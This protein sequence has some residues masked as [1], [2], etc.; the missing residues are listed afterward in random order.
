VTLVEIF[1]VA[2][3]FFVAAKDTAPTLEISI[4]IQKSNARALLI[5]LIVIILS[6]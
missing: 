4:I 3:G 5:F 1:F 6:F 2:A